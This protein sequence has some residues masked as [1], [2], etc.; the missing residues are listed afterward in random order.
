MNSFRLQEMTQARAKAKYTSILCFGSFITL[1]HTFYIYE[2][3][4]SLL[5][6]RLIDTAFTLP[7]M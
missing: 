6:S 4:P 3:Q 7:Y 5:S 1:H 2:T